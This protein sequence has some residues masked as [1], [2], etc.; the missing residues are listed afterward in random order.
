MYFLFSIFDR[1]WQAQGVKIYWFDK[2]QVAIIVVV[3]IHAVCVCFAF[4]VIA[5]F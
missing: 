3:I 2:M 5:I 4:V 1:A